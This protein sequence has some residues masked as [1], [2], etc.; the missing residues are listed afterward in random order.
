MASVTTPTARSR[1]V[2]SRPSSE[3]VERSRQ[4]AVTKYQS[5]ESRVSSISRRIKVCGIASTVDDPLNPEFALT[6][7]KT[8]QFEAGRGRRP[9]PLKAANTSRQSSI[10]VPK[11]MG[12]LYSGMRQ[13]PSSSVSRC[14][15]RI[16][17]LDN[18]TA[19]VVWYQLH[20]T[21][22]RHEHAPDRP[23]QER[24]QAS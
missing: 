11:R 3:R 13:L 15:E 19:T 24:L 1:F 14:L 17:S 2:S 22:R 10:I 21:I 18:I 7:L 4:L 8:G 23:K 12:P 9:R 5:I 16:A 6:H 20:P